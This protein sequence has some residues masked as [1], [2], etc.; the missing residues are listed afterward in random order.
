VFKINRSRGKINICK[1]LDGKL[2]RQT[3]W[4]NLIIEGRMISYWMLER[5]VM[6][7]KRLLWLSVNTLMN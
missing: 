2:E 3:N 5:Y 6:M 7:W 4:E 1:T